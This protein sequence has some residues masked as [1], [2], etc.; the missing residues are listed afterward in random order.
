IYSSMCIGRV[1]NK[2]I[3]NIKKYEF[4]SNSG[5]WIKEPD[6]IIENV[7]GEAS[8]VYDEYEKKFRITYLDS[9][10]KL[11]QSEAIKIEDFVRNPN[12]LEIKDLSGEGKLYYSA[13]EIF[14]TKNHSYIIYMDPGIYQP[15]ILKIMKNY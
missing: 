5:K 11:K 10:L 12:K 6:E 15:I 14:Y 4:L 7:N 3:E 8:I 9:S 13:K 1:K 2:D